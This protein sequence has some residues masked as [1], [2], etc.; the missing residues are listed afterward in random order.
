MTKRK[1]PAVLKCDHGCRLPDLKKAFEHYLDESDEALDFSIRQ[2]NQLAFF[3]S[4]QVLPYL[5]H[6]AHNQGDEDAQDLL[7]DLAMRVYDFRQQ[8]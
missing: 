6:K 2:Y 4:D 7:L 5:E 3:I 1:V 8:F